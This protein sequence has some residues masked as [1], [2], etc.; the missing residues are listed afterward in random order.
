MTRLVYR[1]L[2]YF[3]EEEH[4]AFSV[5]WQL[6]HLPSRWLVYRGQKYRPCQIDKG[7]WM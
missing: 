3:M 7:G 4:E 1:G 2:P 5:W 6:L